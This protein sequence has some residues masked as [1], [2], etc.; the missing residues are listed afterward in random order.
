MGAAMELDAARSAA[1]ICGTVCG[2]GCD[3]GCGFGGRWAAWSAA[4]AVWA[5]AGCGTVC[6]RGMPKKHNF[7]KLLE[8]TSNVSLVRPI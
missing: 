1:H 2:T 5:A 8:E 7:C 4:D 6:G 3:R